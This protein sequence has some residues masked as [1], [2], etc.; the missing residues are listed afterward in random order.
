MGVWHGGPG[1][2]Q[3]GHTSELG[4]KFPDGCKED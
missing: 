3:A 1:K 4:G 2:E